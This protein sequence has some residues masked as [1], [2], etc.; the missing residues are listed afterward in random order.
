MSVPA[1]ST[2]RDNPSPRFTL[3]AMFLFIAVFGCLCGGLVCVREAVKSPEPSIVTEPDDL[4]NCWPMIE[5]GARLANAPLN[6]AEFYRIRKDWD[7]T[8]AIRLAYAPESLTFLIDETKSSPVKPPS[9]YIDEFWDAVP[10]KWTTR[11]ATP[12]AAYFA[13]AGLLAGNDGGR[14]VL[15]HDVPANK[16]YIW[17]HFMF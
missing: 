6:Q 15:M 5:D 4:P 2:G 1:A 7:E 16:I 13:S 3:G 11:A 9:M 8:Y 12:N 10:A 14:F 17:Y